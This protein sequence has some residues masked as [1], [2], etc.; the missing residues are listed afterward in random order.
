MMKKSLLL[1]IVLSLFYAGPAAS[2]G[3]LKK[4]SGAMKDEI[5]GS[6]K[7]GS[8]KN[9]GPEPSCACDSPEL[10]LDL[11]G[12][13]Q[14]N[15]TEISICSRDDGSIIVQDKVTG[16]YYIVKGGVSQG[17]IKDG[18][19][20]IT[21]FNC[22]DNQ[23]PDNNEL[24]VKYKEYIS[25]SGEKY[26]I[27]FAGKTYGPFA[28]I[29]NFVITKS[30]DKFAALVVENIVVTEDDGKKMEE[31]I[32][33]AKTDQE[34]MELAMKYGQQIQEKMMQGGGPESMSTKLV[35]NIAG[36]TFNPNIGGVLNG[37][38]KYDDILVNQFEQVADLQGKTVIT[39]K[40]ELI[41]GSKLY[42]NTTNTKYVVYNYGTLTFSDNVIL[43]DLFN[44][45]LM[46]T[47]GKVYIAY[48]YYSPK[49]N[50]IMQCKI[51]F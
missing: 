20:R 34:R 40:P 7:S 30:K 32:K 24:V 10:I 3:L 5:L 38:M 42:I 22:D 26:L 49:R 41:G 46:K 11:G 43:S 19:P 21:G 50:A 13:L 36:A 39:L 33:N 48:M 16:N 9:Q 44:P 18:D 25:K 29:H 4:V 31:A 12:K 45:R 2:Q 37:D 1:L 51:L 17:P 47:D 35:T 6:N 28:I 15:Y 8:S 27:K 14:L 23:G